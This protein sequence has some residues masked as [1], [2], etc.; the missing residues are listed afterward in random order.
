ML[1]IRRRGTPI[2]YWEGQCNGCGTVA[3]F[4]DKE[5]N[6][7]NEEKAEFLCPICGEGIL[8]MA[9]KMLENAVGHSLNG[10][11]ISAG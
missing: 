4:A 9:W 8:T 1:I 10:M 2:K 11:E 7:G 5:K 6:W 3:I